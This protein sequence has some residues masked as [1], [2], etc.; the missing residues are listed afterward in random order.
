MAATGS[1]SSTF[2]PGLSRQPRAEAK[3]YHDIYRMFAPLQDLHR[4]HPVRLVMLTH[5]RKAEADDIFDTLHRMVQDEQIVRL[6]RGRYAASRSA[7]EG[8]F[9]HPANSGDTW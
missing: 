9:N 7:L 5:L 3:T 6:R 2:S 4:Q 8:E 1:S